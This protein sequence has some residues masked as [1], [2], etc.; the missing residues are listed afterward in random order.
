MLQ[1]VRVQNDAIIYIDFIIIA[2]YNVQDFSIDV[3]S[4]GSVTVTCVFME[5]SINEHCLISFIDTAHGLEN[6]FTAQGFKETN[7]A[8]TESG[9]YTVEVY[10]IVDG[11]IYGPAIVYPELIE[12]IITSPSTT[13]KV[14]K[15]FDCIK[16][17][18]TGEQ[19]STVYTTTSISTIFITPSS[20]I[21]PTSSNNP[22]ESK[23]SDIIGC[24]FISQL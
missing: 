2:T 9:N 18:L 13:S 8:L 14:T 12:A 23:L 11:T 22:Q 16:L 24:Y 7:L 20:I 1:Y 4:N 5:G 10:D 21:T 15:I 3:N 17:F 6:F 19:K